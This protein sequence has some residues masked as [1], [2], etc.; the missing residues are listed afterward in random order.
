ME[1]HTQTEIGLS[2]EQ[3]QE[4]TGGCADCQPD[5]TRAKNA[6]RVARMYLSSA[7]RRTNEGDEARAQSFQKRVQTSMG[8]AQTA[9]ELI[10]ARHPELK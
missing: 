8:S 10:K 1:K 6:I 9:M 5:L 7:E 2:D 4:V 3:L